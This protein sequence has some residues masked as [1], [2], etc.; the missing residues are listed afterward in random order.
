[1]ENPFDH[2]TGNGKPRPPS[3]TDA[4]NKTAAAG[5]TPHD[6]FRRV[7]AD[8]AQFSRKSPATPLMMNP[9][10]A[11]RILCAKTGGGIALG[12]FYRWIRDGRVCTIRMGRKILVPVNMFDDV[13]QKC[14]GGEE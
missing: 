13:I 11:W 14:L 6:M 10:A 1:M 4:A 2:A 9:T 5:K 12:T 3:A 7:S 8:P